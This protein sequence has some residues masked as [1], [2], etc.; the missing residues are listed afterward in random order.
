MPQIFQG[1][2]SKKAAFAKVE[3]HPLLLDLIL[4]K[5]FG[6]DYLEWEPETLWKEVELTFGTTISEVNK[7]RI[8]ALRTCH[9]IDTPYE[10]WDIFEKVAIAFGGGVPKFDVIQKPSSHVCAATLEIMGHIKDRPIAE[11][12]YRY[13]AALLLDEGFAYGPGPLKPCNEF[14]TEHVG[15][16]LQQKVKQ[17]L[18]KKQLPTFDGTRDEDVQ[19]AK[20]LSVQDFVKF[21]SKQLLQQINMVLKRK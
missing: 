20:A 18:A 6:T 14:L 15:L 2:Y 21:D 5:E 17:A 19:I 1:P 16:A 7:N 13:I 4:I 3:A 10:E 11:E 8:Q 12:V 9:V